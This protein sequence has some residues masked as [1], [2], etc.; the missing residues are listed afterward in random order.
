MQN[1]I[2][3]FIFSAEVHLILSK[4][5]ENRMQNTILSLSGQNLQNLFIFS[6]EVHLIFAD[7]A[8]IIFF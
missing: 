5:N 7:K 2:N 3:L 6:A 8:K 1:K 4:D